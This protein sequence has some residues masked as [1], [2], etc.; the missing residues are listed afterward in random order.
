[1]R[2]YTPIIYKIKYYIIAIMN[3]E[4]I[5]FYSQHADFYRMVFSD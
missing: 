5:F 4:E 3:S 2:N 1:M